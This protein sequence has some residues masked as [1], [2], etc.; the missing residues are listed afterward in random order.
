[1]ADTPKKPLPRFG[2]SSLW[3]WLCVIAASA[4]LVSPLLIH[5]WGD[6]S[7][8]GFDALFGFTLA[9]SLLWLVALHAWTR[10]PRSLHLLLL[11]LYLTTAI[12]LFLVDAFGARLSAGYVTIALTDYGDTGE[13][14][15]TYARPLALGA[16]VL[17]VVYLLSLYGMRH[18]RKPR[19]PRVFI[20]AAVSLVAIYGLAIGRDLKE[21]YGARQAAMD[22]AGKELGSPFGVLSQ[23]ALAVDLQV[24][25]AQL[26]AQR[27]AWSFAATKPASG[28]DEVYVLIIGE[29]SRPED[30]SLFGDARDTTPLLRRTPGVVPL[31]HMLTTAPHTAVAVPSMLSLQPITSWSS[32]LAEKSIVGAFNEVGFKTYWLSAQAADTWAGLIPQIAAEALRRRYFDS[33]HDGAML[34]ELHAILATRP[35]PRQFIVLHTKGSH[36]DYARRY[37]PEFDRFATK[38]ATRRQKLVDEYDNSIAYTDWFVHEVIL[39]VERRHARSVVF[40]ASDHG[41]NLLDDE[42]QLLGHALGTRYDLATAA[43]VWTSEEM[44]RARPGQERALLANATAALSLSNVSHSLLDAAGIDARGFDRRKSI[45]SDQFRVVP[46]FYMVRG[47]L[48]SESSRNLLHEDV[49][50]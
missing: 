48:H 2:A 17:L 18:L 47:E 11:P 32:V 8:H 43:L 23:A 36:F 38:A 10:R 6:P 34:E 37:P 4:Y 44:Q 22:V 15:S 30:W 13:L 29:S 12:D 25:S 41:E 46:R 20:G 3:P 19:L 45:F 26:R 9:T 24:R 7:G 31:P 33:G 27:T 40:F 39:E 5:A 42:R 49:P 21:G 35:A 16:A 1:M 14:V 50:K 28:E